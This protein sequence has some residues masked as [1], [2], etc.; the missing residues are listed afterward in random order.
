MKKSPFPA[1][2]IAFLLS[3]SLVVGCDL[4]SPPADDSMTQEEDGSQKGSEATGPTQEQMVRQ[5]QEV[6]DLRQQKTQL[7][8]E[9]HVSAALDAYADARL[10]EAEDHLKAALALDPNDPEVLSLWEEV[11]QAQ[12]DQLDP[13][14]GSG[15]DLRVRLQARVQKLRAEVEANY[16][17]G[18][19]QLDMGEVD[20]AVTNLR[21]AQSKIQ[22]NPYRVDWGDLPQNVD[23]ALARALEVQEIA[24]ATAVETEQRDTFERL[25]AEEE[26]TRE[27]QR[28]RIEL[29]MSDAVQ[30]FENRNYDRCAELAQDVLRIEPLNEQAIELRDSAY[31]A[32]HE[33]VSDRFLKERTVR[34]RKWLLENKKARVPSSEIFQTPDPD[35]WGRITALRAAYRE[36]GLISEEDEENLEIQEAIHTMTIPGLRVEGETSLDAIIDQIRTYTDIPFVVTPDAID[37]VDA[38]GIEFNLDLTNKMTV[39]NALNVI[40]NAAGEQVTYTF[41]NGVVYVTTTTKAQGQLWPVAHDVQDLTAQLVDFSGPKI[42]EIRLPDTSTIGIDEE[43]PA[44]GGVV[45]EPRSLM[46]AENLEILIRQ[47]IAP[48]SWDEVDGVSIRYSNGFLIVVHT[49]EV[50]EQIREFLD[51]VR[52]FVSSVVTIESRFLIVQKD[53]LNEIGVDFR[54]LGGTFAPPTSLVNLDD[55]TSGLE[56]N[57]SRALDNNGPGLPSGAESNPSA[58]AFFNEGMDGD[59]RVR[60][61][62]ILMAAGERLSSIGGLTMQF[63]F[64]DDTQTSVILRAVE[65]DNRAQELNSSTISVQNTGRGYMTVL[66]QVTYVQDM[67]VEVAQAAIIADPI[68]GV[69][70]DGIVLDVRP[71]ISHDR[72][73]ITLELRPTVA[74]LLRPIPEFTSSL[75]GL[76]TPVTIQLPEIQVSSTNTTAVIPDGGTVVVGGLKKL[77]NVDQRAEVPFLAKIPVLGILFKSEQQ[78]SEQQDVIILIR[79]HITDIREAMAVLEKNATR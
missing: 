27:A 66:N 45:G 55:V 63:V 22:A 19:R 74:S 46:N 30:A 26:A 21:L 77:L 76:T 33:R 57:A 35:H 54:G 6:A 18:V 69:V 65:K 31:R 50:Q 73:Y 34:F 67:D 42:N 41:K 51:E 39:A 15:D 68:V 8:V 40:T 44:F 20:V 60:S 29:M 62:N 37:A 24:R 79:A 61:E 5:T 14:A 4:I 16:Q 23:A 12:G 2:R 71:T 53:F 59:V 56:D 72:K 70:S 38:E 9:E 43:E 64:F 32:R 13:I 17:T 10:F 1:V 7:L 11:R 58:G 75:A 28:R 25:Q 52:R 3:L 47:T 78:V 36:L 48:L 49:Q